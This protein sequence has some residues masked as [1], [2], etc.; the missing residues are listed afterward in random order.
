MRDRVLFVQLQHRW[1]RVLS[2]LISTGLHQR[3]LLRP[4]PV[5][6][7]QLP[8]WI[9]PFEWKLHCLHERHIE[10]RH[11]NVLQLI[12]FYVYRVLRRLLR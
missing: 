6:V 10:L 3:V 8:E 9:L 5:A 4:V 7:R 11:H 2:V 1:L 12:R